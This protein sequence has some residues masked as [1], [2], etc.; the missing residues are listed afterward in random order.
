M[1]KL[2]RPNV[3]VLQAQAQ[4]QAPSLDDSIA[5]ETPTAITE[6]A[7]AEPAFNFTGLDYETVFAIHEESARLLNEWEAE[8]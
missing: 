5:T 2:N 6:S 3:K 8:S 7:P 1:R 4:K